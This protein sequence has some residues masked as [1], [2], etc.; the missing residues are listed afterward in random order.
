MD[1]RWISAGGVER[2]SAEDIAALLGRDD[3]FLWVDIPTCHE[4]ASRTLSD[5]FG[6]H[7]LAVRACR[8]RSHVPRLR[9]YPDHLFIVLH[10]PEAGDAGHVHLV[11]LDLFVGLR[12]LVTVH[13]PLG[14]GVTP[15][16]ALQD[17]GAVLRRMEEGRVRPSSP[18]ELSH[19]IASALAGRMESF[20][21]ELAT[22]VAAM[23]RRVMEGHVRD[24]EQALEELFRVRH[25]LLTV[26]TMAAQ[27]TEVYARMSSLV[28]FLPEGTRPFVED[29]VDRF[30]RI[31]NMC[32]GEKEFL[33]GVVDF[34][35]SR[36]ATKMNIAI[37]RLA[38]IAALMM[39]ITA[40]AAIYGMNIIV[41]RQTSPLHVGGVLVVMGAVMTLM[42][43]WARRHGWW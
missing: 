5:T 33:Q 2:R 12:Y 34:Y 16:V 31:R 43:R 3:G 13:G 8:D 18:A 4:E 9:T 35:Q 17:T 19:A 26:R 30:D 21:A 7:P 11:E 37:E 23:E 29:V 28:S 6:F 41:P 39:P 20:V 24:P 15:E 22:R 38:L 36:T 40:V 10:A 14:E 1:V 25:E 42:L 32:D 27:S